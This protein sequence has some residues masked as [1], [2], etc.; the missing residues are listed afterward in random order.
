MNPL[1]NASDIISFK[2]LLESGHSPNVTC[3]GQ[4]ILINAARYNFKD[5]VEL[6]IKSGANVNYQDSQGLTA[7][8]HATKKG[9]TD[10]VEILL[11]SGADK[12]IRN[13]SEKTCKDIAMSLYQEAS[14]KNPKTYETRKSLEKING[15]IDYRD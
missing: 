12:G 6:L 11:D 9:H 4:S 10:V 7:L 14:L 2:S 8:M 3:N 13:N 1:F 15:I 5:A